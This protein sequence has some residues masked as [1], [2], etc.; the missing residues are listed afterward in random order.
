MFPFPASGYE[1]RTL[2]LGIDP[3]YDV[4]AL[5]TGLKVPSDGVFGPVTDKA[6]KAFQE[7]ERVAGGADGK[8]GP[9]TQEALCLHLLWP[10]QQQYGVVPGLARGMMKGES[11]YYVGNQSAIYVLPSDP[12]KRKRADL[13]CCQFQTILTDDASVRQHFNM[14][15]SIEELC[16]FLREGF[17]LYWRDGNNPHVTSKELAW[18][19]ACGRW[20]APAWTDEI[21]SKGTDAVADYKVTHIMDYISTK[22]M[23]VTSWG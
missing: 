13:G 6:L 8:G 23:Y 20:N 7:A 9:A 22:V 5:Q 17:D 14:P 4:M 12:Q 18:K 19:L 15:K 21:A 1:Y 10:Y 3:G 11:N 2:K 16:R